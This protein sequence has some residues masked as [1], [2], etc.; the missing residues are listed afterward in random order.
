MKTAKKNVEVQKQRFFSIASASA[1]ETAHANVRI[2][3]ESKGLNEAVRF[4][5]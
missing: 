3:E 5:V 4:A 1:W 2:R